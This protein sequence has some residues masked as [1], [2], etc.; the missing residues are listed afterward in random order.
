MPNSTVVEVS[1]PISPLSDEQNGADSMY[2][3]EDH[4]SLVVWQKDWFE[5]AYILNLKEQ[6]V[7]SQVAVDKVI[8]CTKELVSDILK[9]LMDDVR[10]SVP[11]TIVKLLEDRVENISKSLFEHLSSASLQ[12]SYFRKHFNLV[13]SML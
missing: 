13:V 3:E 8:S 5:A 2:T 10:G 6:Y 11:S 1:R 4:G 9:R 7:L 12:K